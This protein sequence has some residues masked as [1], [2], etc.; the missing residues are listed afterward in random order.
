MAELIDVVLHPTPSRLAHQIRTNFAQVMIS[1]GDGF[2]RPAASRR[3]STN[4]PSPIES[5][6]RRC[7]TCTPL[8]VNH[9]I[10]ERVGW[11]LIF[12]Q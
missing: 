8:A 10:A 2:P 1:S 3:S 7:R 5:K 4:I 6:C 12:Q 11:L 9:Q